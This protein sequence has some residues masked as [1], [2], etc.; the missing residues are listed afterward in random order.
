MMRSTASTRVALWVLRSW[1]RILERSLG[2]TD[3]E[4]HALAT[5]RPLAVNPIDV[6][7][8][9]RMNADTTETLRGMT[10]AEL[11]ALCSVV[12][13][14]RG[15]SQDVASPLG[16]DKALV[17]EEVAKLQVAAPNPGRIRL[18]HPLRDAPRHIASAFDAKQ[19]SN[20]GLSAIVKTFDHCGVDPR[21]HVAVFTFSPVPNSELEY[22]G[23][24]ST[25]ETEPL[26]RRLLAWVRPVPMVR[27]PKEVQ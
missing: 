22:F 24:A 18:V 11:S 19:L 10:T 26:Q 17:D 9:R 21:T 8:L 23:F 16:V 3:V 25:C 27:G 2:P 12:T 14:I 4:I 20:I 1:V 13:A 15:V 6:D 7:A 5:R